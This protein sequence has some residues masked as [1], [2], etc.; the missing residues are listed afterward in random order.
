MRYQGKISTWK[1]ERG[2]GFITPIGGKT[3]I[4]VHISAFANRERRPVA[5]EIVSFEVTT[6]DKGRVQAERV[7]FADE[8]MPPAAADGYSNVPLILVGCFFAFLVGAVFVNALP[9]AVLWL[10]LASSVLTFIAYRQDKSAAENRQWRTQERT[11][12][13]LGLLG[14][15]PGGLAAQNVLRHKSR[16]QS[17]QVEFWFTCVLNCT[18]LG[19]LFSNSGAALL[20][21]I[22]GAE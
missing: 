22:L 14:G 11:L 19:W 6:D 17:F 2:F 21:A 1:D 15:W 7:A 9:L 10:Y 12:H 20:R 3:R 4:F 18:A 5:D 13:L 8:A 16:K